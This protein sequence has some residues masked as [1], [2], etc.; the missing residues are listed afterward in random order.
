VRLPVRESPHL[1]TMRTRLPLFI[2]VLA[3]SALIV[4]AGAAVSAAAPSHRGRP[5]VHRSLPAITGRPQA[6]NVL[7]AS[8][9]RWTGARSVSY[10]WERCNAAARRCKLVMTFKGRPYA[11]R[12]YKLSTLDVGHRLRVRV[13]AANAWGTSSAT[14]RPTAV[15]TKR[16]ATGGTRPGSGSPASP[17][18]APAPGPGIGPTGGGPTGGGSGPGGGTTPSYFSTVPSSQAGTPPAGIPRPDATCAAAV[19][20]TPENRPQNATANHNVPPDSSAIDWGT[21]L[22]YWTDFVADRNHVTGHY[23]GTTDEILQWVSCKWGIDV[24]LVRADAVIESYWVQSTT[25]DNC[26]VPGEASYGLLQVKNKDCSGNWVHGGWPYT[27]N[28]SALDVDYW[29]ARLRACFDGA[30]Y[31]GGQWLYKGQTIAQVIAQHGEDYALWGCVGSWFSGGWYDSGAQ[32][33]I[34]NVQADYQSK[35]WLKPGF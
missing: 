35:P 6:G 9:G 25:G 19:I 33:Y 18:P 32:S 16:G 34:A 4:A 23:T 10:R 7:R 3:I 28:D 17:G 8:P 30:F 24:D 26:G 5:P 15:V 20:P 29:G 13:R 27:Q 1:I 2:Y 14:S 21:A 31:N 12:T 22:N 11:A